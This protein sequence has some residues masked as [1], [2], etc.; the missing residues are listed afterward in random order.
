LSGGA[1]NDTF[2]F[3]TGTWTTADTLDGGAGTDL[4]RILGAQVFAVA[5]EPTTYRTTNIETVQI[6]DALAAQT[7]TPA[8][9]SAGAT[10][11][12]VTGNTTNGGVTLT[13]GA[14]LL[15]AGAAPTI[16]GPAGAFTIGLGTSLA[17]NLLGGLG[18]LGVATG[19]AGLVAGGGEAAGTV[20][21]N[22]TGT[23]TTDT[24]TIINSA[25]VTSGA[26]VNVYNSAP[27]AING[28]ETVTIN[29]GPVTGV[30]NVFGAITLAGD[31]SSNTR[32]NFTGVNAVNATAAITASV[33]DASGITASGT[34]TAANT[35]AFFMNAAPT[36]TTV[37]GSAGIDVLLGNAGIASSVDGGAG[38]DSITGGG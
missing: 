16:V 13:T 27:F 2:W 10:R 35:A 7:Y 6:T 22:D 18:T 25:R 3:S 30:S 26:A 9:I 15:A 5:T 34:G 1:G 21:I 32:L 4:L 28:Y 38:N 23:A 12:N 36:A 11:L 37:I 20:T 29:T 8:F 24:L 33:I 19:Q 14:A 31:Q 17:A